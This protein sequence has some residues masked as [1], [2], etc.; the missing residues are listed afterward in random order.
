MCISDFGGDG[1]RGVVVDS[2]S[3]GVIRIIM[4]FKGFFFLFI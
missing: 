4:E 2:N 3:D 1:I